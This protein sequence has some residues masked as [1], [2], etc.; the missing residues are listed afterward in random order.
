MV[1]VLIALGN[2]KVIVQ[3]YWHA[4][5]IYIPNKFARIVSW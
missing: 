3:K 1:F 4:K 2:E 5:S